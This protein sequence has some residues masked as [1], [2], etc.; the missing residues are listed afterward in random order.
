[1]PVCK[2]MSSATKT[3][4]KLKWTNDLVKQ[5]R[6]FSVG[7]K[8]GIDAVMSSMESLGGHR[9]ASFVASLTT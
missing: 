1:M 2:V 6:G 7:A 5:R 3:F 8:A 9:K 4:V